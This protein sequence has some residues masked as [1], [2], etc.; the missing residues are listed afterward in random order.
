MDKKSPEL[1]EDK[2]NHDTNDPSLNTAEVCR[3]FWRKVDYFIRMVRDEH[4]FGYCVGMVLVVEFQKRGL[5]HA[6][7]ILTLAKK[8]RTPEEVDAVVT[9]AIPDK[10]S[11]PE[12]FNLV[13][14]KMVHQECGPRCMRKNRCSKGYPMAWRDETTLDDG[15]GFVAM[16]RPFEPH[17][18]RPQEP[19]QQFKLGGKIY[20]RRSIVPYNAFLLRRLGCHVNVVP[21][22]SF[23][24]VSYLF[25][26]VF[27]GGDLAQL[28]MNWKPTS[29]KIKVR[30]IFYIFQHCQKYL[31][32][33]RYINITNRRKT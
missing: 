14:T 33:L 15:R 13:T 25:K 9:T 10:K 28:E 19:K 2:K 30:V 12:L 24:Q 11:D 16:K 21:V 26:Y 32:Q 8:I 22:N 31:Q 27:K 23:R 7:A 3:L 1:I 18:Q 17:P 6:H 5:P 29:Y 20:D 4:I